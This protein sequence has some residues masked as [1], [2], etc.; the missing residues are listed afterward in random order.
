[1]GQQEIGAKGFDFI[2]KPLRGEDYPS[3]VKVWDNADDAIFDEQPVHYQKVIVL[4]DQPHLFEAQV[5]VN[6]EVAFVKRYKYHAQAVAACDEYVYTIIRDGTFGE[7][8]YIHVK[9]E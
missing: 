5:I 1:M 8:P 2:D 3:L 6:G 4:T 7:G 9:G